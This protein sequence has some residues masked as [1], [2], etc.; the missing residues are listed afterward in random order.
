MNKAVMTDD[1]ER[2]RAAAIVEL[3]RR[4]ASGKLID[5]QIEELVKL[6]YD[7]LW[8][9]ETQPE[10]QQLPVAITPG[11]PPEIS[12]LVSPTVTPPDQQVF[13]IERDRADLITRAVSVDGHSVVVVD[14]IRDRADKLVRLILK[15][16][17][18]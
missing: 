15:T 5:Q 13:N 4:G 12:P 18:H 6:A 17:V 7:R 10:T 8:Q 9:S 1:Q 3:A 14:L 11:L 16:S 2:G